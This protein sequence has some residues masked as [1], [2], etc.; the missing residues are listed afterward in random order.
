MA[1]DHQK[2]KLTLRDIELSKLRDE[3]Y[4]LKNCQIDFIRLAT[5]L[6]GI[7][8]GVVA[9]LIPFLKVVDEKIFNSVHLL[10]YISVIAL[11]PIIYPYIGWVIIHKCRSIFR[12][13][14]Y[15]R[16]IEE[17]SLKD[18]KTFLESYFGYETLH[19][20]LREHPWV[21][22]RISSFSNLIKKFFNDSKPY[23]KQVKE[24]NQ[25]YDEYLK[26]RN[27]N[28]EI[29][30]LI[31]ISGLDKKE[32][33]VYIGDYYGRLLFFVRLIGFI[34]TSVIVVLAFIGMN[35]SAGTFHF[36]FLGI[37][38]G[39]SLWFF[40]HLYLSRKFL[41][42]LRY[43]PFSMDGYYDMW[44]WAIY[45]MKQPPIISVEIEN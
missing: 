10:S 30:K 40:F 28:P 17:L 7:V 18:K 20:K 3:I 25:R 8:T 19:R 35:N 23:G 5:I 1:N 11:I 34:G 29:P 24:A 22:I 38:V 32:K 13:V 21:E 33:G 39:F 15:I 31:S 4:D 42:E 37:A 45:E 16:I 27:N 44:Q 43:R 9:A 12:I 6:V 26:L 14:S 2:A 36:V 41:R